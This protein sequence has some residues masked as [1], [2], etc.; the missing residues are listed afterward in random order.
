MLSAHQ[1]NRGSLDFALNWFTNKQHIIMYSYY[2]FFLC[3]FG[4][5]IACYLFLN[6]MFL[7]IIYSGS[8]MTVGVD[9]WPCTL[10]SWWFISNISLTARLCKMFV[11]SHVHRPRNNTTPVTAIHIHFDS[12][13]STWWL[14]ILLIK[15]WTFSCSLLHV[16]MI[17]GLLTVSP[18][19]IKNQTQY[20]IIVK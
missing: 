20:K 8:M 15:E 19:F 10:S 17:F 2:Y 5:L 18:P 14:N 7:F 11:P 3:I 4:D 12:I 13:L 6:L 9:L 1:F 16:W